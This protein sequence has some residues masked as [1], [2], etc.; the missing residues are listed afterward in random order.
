M[1]RKQVAVVIAAAFFLFSALLVSVILYRSFQGRYGDSFPEILSKIDGLSMEGE[2]GKALSVLKDARKKAVSTSQ[3]LSLAKREIKLEAME[4]AEETLLSALKDFP[5]ND[6]LS[7]VLVYV[8]LRE[9]KIQSARNY[10]QFLKGT[11]FSSLASYTEIISSMPE[12]GS[13]PDFVSMNPDSYGNAW[14]VTGNPVFRRDAAVLYAAG[15]NYKQAYDIVCSEPENLSGDSVY[16]PLEREAFFQALIAYDAGLYGEVTE[17]FFPSN[18]MFSEEMVQDSYLRNFP[19]DEILLAADAFYMSGDRSHADSLW[20][21]LASEESDSPVPFFNHSIYA[22]SWAEKRSTLENCLRKFPAYYPAV[23][24]YVRSALPADSP[25]VVLYGGNRNFA[26]EALNEAGFVSVAMENAALNKPVTLPEARSVL[27]SALLVC[28]HSP[29]LRINLE[30]VRFLCFQNGKDAEARHKLWNLLEV[31]NGNQLV[32]DFAVWF[33][34]SQGD[35]NLA[36]EILE[37]FPSPDPVYNGIAAA[38]TGNIVSA[39]QL[40]TSAADLEGT[41]SVVAAYANSAVILKKQG[42]YNGAADSFVMAA[43]M[44]GEPGL[45]SRLYYE[46]AVVFQLQKA[47]V[48]AVDMLRHSVS[49]DKDNYSAKVLLRRLESAAGV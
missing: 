3:W 7:A 47:Y 45:K 19:S 30:E 1:K 16:Q 40:F 44:S 12:S 42:N 9:N 11:D 20:K 31:Y 17:I 22:P 48:R 39:L 27:D 15:G 29:D 33:F 35:F 21:F 14:N 8:F 24:S 37:D 49:L 2:K 32:L 28:A 18:Y 34:S 13:P 46:A 25:S 36:F 38:S 6:R 43:E 4:Q 41:P 26:E 5:V 10:I 23:V